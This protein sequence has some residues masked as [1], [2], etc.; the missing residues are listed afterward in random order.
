MTKSTAAIVANLTADQQ[1]KLLR[2]AARAT[3]P[4]SVRGDT[5]T[6][7][8]AYGSGLSRRVVNAMRK[9]GHGEKIFTGTGANSGRWYFPLEILERAAEAAQSSHVRLKLYAETMSV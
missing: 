5:R 6:R 9:E 4:R 7:F 8:Y 1:V 3:E 2:E